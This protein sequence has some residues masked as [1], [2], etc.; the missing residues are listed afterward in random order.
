LKTV[1]IDLWTTEQ[2]T[3]KLRVSRFARM[4]NGMKATISVIADYHSE[5]K[6]ILRDEVSLW[7]LKDRQRF[8]VVC[9]AR[10]GAAHLLYNGV[11]RNDELLSPISA[12]QAR[13]EEKLVELED[14]LLQEQEQAPVAHESLTR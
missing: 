2:A 4:S 14:M 7:K 12:C 8:A 6:E 5:T 10:C 3:V 13:I 1:E 11:Y 9:W